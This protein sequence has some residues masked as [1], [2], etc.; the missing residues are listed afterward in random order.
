MATVPGAML[1]VA[2]SPYARRGAVFDA[3]REHHGQPSDVLVWK[4]PTRTMNP[5]VPQRFID[6]EVERDPARAAAEYGAEF[7]TDIEGFVSREVVDAA[8]VPGRHELPRV[9]G[10]RYVAAVDPSG[11]GSDAMTLAITHRDTKG[12]AILDVVRERRPPFSP[13]AVV[14]EFA[15]VCKA[16]GVTKVTGD[17]WGG[18]FVREPFRKLGIIYALAERPKSDFYFEFLPIL[19]SA[20]VELLDH[21]RF[22]SQLC[23]LERRTARSGKDSIDHPPGGHDDLVNVVAIAV[24]LA[25][26]K[27]AT[28]ILSPA[29]LKKSASMPYTRQRF[30]ALGP[31]DGGR[32]RNRFGR[33]L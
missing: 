17:H 31:L 19:N 25:A 12:N 24:V 21:P 26:A 14:A 3:F 30:G 23:T 1:L 18:E 29:A 7:R 16:Y 22:I 6:R 5:T 9:T 20:R 32:G 27:H 8:V 33:S 28:M 10:I 13:E 2:S 11:S 4:A 15:A